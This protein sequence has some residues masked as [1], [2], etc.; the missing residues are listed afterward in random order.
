M[1]RIALI[2]IFCGLAPVLCAQEEL[3][4]DI[5]YH[6]NKIHFDALDAFDPSIPGYRSWPFRFL[7]KIHNRTSDSFIKRELLFREGEPLDPDL[8]AESERNLRKHA[9]LDDVRI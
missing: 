4:P 5:Q 2:L 7:N 3:T 6:I 8:V 9:F 1:N